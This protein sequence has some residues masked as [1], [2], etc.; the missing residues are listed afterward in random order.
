MFM[1]S[2]RESSVLRMD[3]STMEWTKLGAESCAGE[4][5][6]LIFPLDFLQRVDV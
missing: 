4:G 3:T 5:N 6:A 2:R 1:V